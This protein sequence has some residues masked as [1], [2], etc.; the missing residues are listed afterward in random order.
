MKYFKGYKISLFYNIVTGLNIYSNLLLQTYSFTN[1]TKKI[2]HITR[3]YYGKVSVQNV[4]DIQ[5]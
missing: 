5:I 2:R 4:H 3:G 1:I